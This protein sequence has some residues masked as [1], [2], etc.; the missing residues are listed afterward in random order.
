[1]NVLDVT[2]QYIDTEGGDLQKFW[3]IESTGTSSVTMSD[4]NKTFLNLTIIPVIHV[5]PMVH[6]LLD[7]HG[8]WVIPFTNQPWNM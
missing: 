1:M 2:T 8:R 7:S 6:K 3:A 5:N 4:S